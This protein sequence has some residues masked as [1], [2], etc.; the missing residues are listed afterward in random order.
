MV[1]V[2]LGMDPVVRKD[3][4]VAD[5]QNLTQDFALQESQPFK[6]VKSAG[7]KA[8]PLADDINSASFADAPD[9]LINEPWQ[10]QLDLGGTGT[11]LNWKPNEVSGRFRIKYSDTA[12]H[13]ASDVNFKTPGVNNWPDVGREIWDGNHFDLFLQSDAFDPKRTTLELD[14][15]WQAAV[16]LSDAPLFKVF[17]NG[18][19]PE[20]QDLD[21]L[22]ENQSIGTYILRKVKAGGD[23]ELT[24]VDYPWTLFHQASTGKGIAPPADN[25]F[26]ALDLSVGA[27]DPDVAKEEATIKNRLSWSGYFEGWR[28]PSHLKPVVFTPTP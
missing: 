5:G 6:I 26:G 8:I 17:Q 28:N 20:G 19:P 18:A 3:V 4:T 25:S 16:R 13:L 24:R 21:V 27:S 22:T 14:H 12:L 10:I 9:I 23:G 7:G 15:N 1:A 2:G 11:F